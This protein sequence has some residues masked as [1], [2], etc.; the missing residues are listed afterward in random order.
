MPD[1]L[2]VKT[3]LVAWLKEHAFDGLCGH[4]CGCGIDDLALCDEIPP[5]CEPGYRGPD[6]DGD[7]DFIIYL[8]H[9]DVEAAK[10]EVRE[11]EADHA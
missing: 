4:D 1:T 3:I 7:A 6:P 8:S 2:N 9:D 5:D 11:Q 10:A